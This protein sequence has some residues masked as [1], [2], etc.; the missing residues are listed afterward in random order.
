MVLKANLSKIADFVRS[1]AQFK[2][3]LQYIVSVCG[4]ARR[5][6]RIS[7]STKYEFWKTKISMKM[8]VKRV[9]CEP[10]KV[11]SGLLIDAL[12]EWCYLCF[13]RVHNLENPRVLA[14]WHHSENID[15]ALWKHRWHQK[16]P[17]KSI[18]DP[19]FGGGCALREDDIILKKTP[20]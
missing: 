20:L 14:P 6:R 17:R 1:P 16:K 10:F 4:S 9:I 15:D 3:I 2:N 19:V 13:F 7:N 18:D 12:S 11:I 8:V 5:R